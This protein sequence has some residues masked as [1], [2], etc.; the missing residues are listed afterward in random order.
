MGWSRRFKGKL[1][2][3]KEVQEVMP[4]KSQQQHKFMYAVHPKI[5]ARWSKETPKGTKLPKRKKKKK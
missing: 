5:A 3:G 4:F 2:K 1:P